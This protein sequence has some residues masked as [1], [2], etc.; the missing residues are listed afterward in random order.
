M[1]P[2]IFKR[3]RHLDYTDDLGLIFIIKVHLSTLPYYLS[4]FSR[5][6]PLIF[7][8]DNASLG[9]DGSSWGNTHKYLQ[10]T[11]S[12]ASSGDE[13]R[14]AEGT[15]KPVR[16]TG[17]TPGDVTASFNLVSGVEMYSGFLGTDLT[18]YI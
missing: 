9:G 2:L 11:L 18:T 3:I 14:V 17:K 12:A 4:A 8:D 1:I 10:V 7:V 16:G 13:I 6:C 15:Y 5:R